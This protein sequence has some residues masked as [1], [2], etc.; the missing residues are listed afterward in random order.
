VHEAVLT[1]AN[2]EDGL[3]EAAVLFA[4]ALGFRHVALGAAVFGGTGSGGHRSNLA[5]R[6]EMGNVPLVTCV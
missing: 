3:A 6:G 5:L 4:L 2:F 1:E